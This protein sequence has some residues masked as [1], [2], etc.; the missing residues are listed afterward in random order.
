MTDVRVFG[1][2]NCCLIGGTVNSTGD[3]GWKLGRIGNG[4]G[5]RGERGLLPVIEYSSMVGAYLT[6]LPFV[7]L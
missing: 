3:E 5:S 2:Y 7:R 1:V 4:D 6:F